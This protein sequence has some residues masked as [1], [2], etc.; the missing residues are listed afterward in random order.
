MFDTLRSWLGTTRKT[1]RRRYR[2]NPSTRLYVEVLPD[3]INPSRFTIEV[4]PPG[5]GM[6]G[7]T[8]ATITGS[9]NL[10]A[11]LP[12]DANGAAI[13]EASSIQ[14]AVGLAVVGTITVQHAGETLT[15]A[16]GPGNVGATAAEHKPFRVSSSSIQ[17]EDMAGSATGSDWD[18]N[19]HSWVIS[20]A[21]SSPLP[22]V[23]IIAT[24]DTMEGNPSDRW[25]LIHR[26]DSTG[27]ATVN[28][29]APAGSATLGTDYTGLEGGSVTFPV[30]VSDVQLFVHALQDATV[31]GRE[32]V[33][34]T[35]AGGP[36]VSI[37]LYDD[38]GGF[39]QFEAAVV[40][41]NGDRTL[42]FP[43][44]AGDLRPC[45]HGWGNPGDLGYRSRIMMEATWTNA[46]KF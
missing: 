10:N 23:S 19:D 37:D 32:T 21:P 30:G 14:K 36:T 5:V 39:N 28:Y 40:Y 17:L 29:S 18:Y 34:L 27:P 15:Y 13:V 9:L 8:A 44:G 24:S 45:G 22:A 33:V 26:S 42:Y 11:Q 16:M 6:P 2:A 20:V 12:T 3:R 4:Q 7:D 43:S 1:P 25:F 38:D 41:K 35:L 31:E 46:K